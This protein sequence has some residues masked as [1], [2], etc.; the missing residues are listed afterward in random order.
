M[1]IMKVICA[2]FIS[3]LI[4]TACAKPPKMEMDKAIEAVIRAENDS[5]AALYSPNTLARARDA[6][7]RME[8]EADSKKY[9]AAKTYAAEAVT[10]AEKALTDGRASAIR[11]RDEAAVLINGLKQA[12]SETEQGIRYARSSGLA[13]DFSDLNNE[14]NKLTL[15]TNKA[16]L[17]M[18]GSQYNQALE[19]GRGVQAGLS[20]INLKLSGAAMAV[21]RKK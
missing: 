3:I 8:K 18:S 7:S 20:D 16:E 19:I 4:I 13:L 6:L 14:F 5:D 11:V 1:K 12:L 21:S 15:N 9:D 17:A 10:L 2:I